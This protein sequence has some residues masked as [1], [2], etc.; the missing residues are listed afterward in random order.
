MFSWIFLNT[1]NTFKNMFTAAC[2]HALTSLPPATADWVMQ[3]AEKD[4]I[5][6]ATTIDSVRGSGEFISGKG[7]GG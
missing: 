5:L 4:I 2:H 6:L 1:N 7:V 3:G